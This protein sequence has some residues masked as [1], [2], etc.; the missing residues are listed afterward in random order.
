MEDKEASTHICTNCGGLIYYQPYEGQEPADSL[1][2]VSCPK[3]GN[4]I[5][6][7]AG[8]IVMAFDRP[9]E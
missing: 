2:I 9:E 5:P 7:L 1:P 3:C 8:A 6:E 4:V